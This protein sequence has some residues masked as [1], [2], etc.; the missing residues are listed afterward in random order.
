MN[1]PITRPDDYDRWDPRTWP[2]YDDDAH[3][4]IV[5]TEA[6]ELGEEGTCY[7][8]GSGFSWDDFYT[9]I[10]E[11]LHLN[12]PATTDAP[13]FG[14]IQRKARKARQEVG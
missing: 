2:I 4:A 3:R 10:E 12:L 14:A 1:D 13:I 7:Y 11:R 9:K 6:D 8:E 5:L